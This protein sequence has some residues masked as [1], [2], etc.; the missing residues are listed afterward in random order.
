MFTSVLKATS[1]F[2]L[3][4]QTLDEEQLHFEQYASKFGECRFSDFTRQIQPRDFVISKD[5]EEWKFVERL[6]P[7]GTN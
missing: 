1:Y 2:S 5:P 6:L 7:L 3:I 4:F